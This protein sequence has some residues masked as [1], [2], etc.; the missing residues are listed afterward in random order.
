MH[1]LKYEKGV[2]GHE[3]HDLSSQRVVIT[4]GMEFSE[5]YTLKYFFGMKI[6]FRKMK[7]QQK[8]I[9]EF[10]VIEPKEK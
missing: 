5:D 3:L 2:E 4:R 8:C 1:R 9:I 10:N 7:N 6:S